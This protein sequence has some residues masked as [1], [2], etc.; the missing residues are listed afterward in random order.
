VIAGWLFLVVLVLNG[1]TQFLVPLAAAMPLSVGRVNFVLAPSL[2]AVVLLRTR[3]SPAYRALGAVLLCL[4]V[5]VLGMSPTQDRLWVLAVS[6]LLCAEVFWL[7]PRIN[8]R[9]RP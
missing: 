2:A 3:L 4:S 9:L 5:I 6:V 7:L 8:R 1:F